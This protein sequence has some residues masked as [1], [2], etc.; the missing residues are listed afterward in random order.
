MGTR[1]LTRVIPRQEGV[2][3]ADALVHYDKA[4]VEIYRQYDGYPDGHGLD[5]AEFIDSKTVVNGLS[6]DTSDVA[7]GP[8]CLAA[9]LVAKLKDRA[10]NIYLQRPDDHEGSW[11]EYI[12]T[13]FPKVGEETYVALHSGDGECLF[14]GT[15]YA[16]IRKYDEKF[17]DSK[18]QDKEDLKE[19][20]G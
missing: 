5:V 4:I 7:N 16:F 10:G 20:R 17:V 8:E 12:Y 6:G 14:V 13:I 18:F 2:N 1:S 9:M 3:F 15:A 11:C 19:V